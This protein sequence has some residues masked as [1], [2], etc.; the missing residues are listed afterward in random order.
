VRRRP[1]RPRRTDDGQCARRFAFAG[2]RG[3]YMLTVAGTVLCLV[4]DWLDGASAEP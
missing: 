3:A 4:L 2:S 1:L